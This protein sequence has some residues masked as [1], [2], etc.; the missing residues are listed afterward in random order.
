MQA[1]RLKFGMEIA[2]G[3]FSGGSRSLDK[4]CSADS[5]QFGAKVGKSQKKLKC[6]LARALAP[7]NWAQ[8]L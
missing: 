1:I 6:D 3:R 2:N 7:S 8:L 5:A 4:I